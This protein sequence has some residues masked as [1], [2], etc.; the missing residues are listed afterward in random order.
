M[1]FLSHG[2]SLVTNGQIDMA[3]RL[4]D[5]IATTLGARRKA[6]EHHALFDVD[7]FDLEF[8]DIS[9]VIVFSV[10]D[11]KSTRLNYS[12]ITISYAVFCLKKKKKKQQTATRY[13]RR[14]KRTR[15]TTVR[16]AK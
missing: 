14:H 5:P 3:G 4:A 15:N 16:T 6:L 2:F 7:H 10:G 12:H 11:R 1:N 8:V 13:E 9:A